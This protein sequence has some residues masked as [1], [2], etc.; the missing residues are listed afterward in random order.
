MTHDSAAASPAPS[1]DTGPADSRIEELLA[2][3]GAPRPAFSD[4]ELLAGF[5]AVTEQTDAVDGPTAARV[6]TDTRQAELGAEA[7]AL[8]M[9]YSGR[10]NWERAAYWLQL[11]ARSG[12]ADASYELQTLRRRRA[13]S[14]LAGPVHAP[15]GG[16]EDPAARLARL[17]RGFTRLHEAK[18][19]A[20]TLKAI[21]EGAVQDLDYGVACFNLV[22]PDGDL[23]VVSVAGDETAEAFL[24]GRVGP[25]ARWDARL[26][27]GERWGDVVFVSHQIGWTADGDGVPSWRGG[28]GADPA[29]NSWHAEDR[30]LAEVRTTTGSLLGVL[31]VDLP[32]SGLLP[33]PW[34]REALALY[35][36]EVGLALTAARLRADAE[37][38]RVRLEREDDPFQVS[39]ARARRALARSSWPMALAE[40]P[41]GLPSRLLDVNNAL[42]Q[43]LDRA[44]NALR[45]FSLE[46]L[47]HPDDLATWLRVSLTRD[48]CRVRLVRRD[49][50]YVTTAVSAVPVATDSGTALPGGLGTPGPTAP[51]CLITLDRHRAGPSNGHPTLACDPLTG[52][53][54]GSALRSE[55]R[56]LCATADADGP[57][58]SLALLSVG[59]DDFAQLNVAHGPEAGDTV[60]VEVVQRL[61]RLVG[62]RDVVARVGGDEFVL[63]TVGRTYQQIEELEPRVLAALTHPVRIGEATVQ[64][65]ASV[66]RGWARHGMTAEQL[67]DTADQDMQFAKTLRK[68]ARLS[69]CG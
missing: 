5:R 59:L 16:W 38:A 57:A 18:S 65:S 35:A 62:P 64:L 4:D 6:D 60:L 34:E 55:L 27:M 20:H 50:S 44:P 32:R 53:V 3:L 49:G 56:R 21:S 10:Q 33:G 54:T 37:R 66:G 28:A 48:T 12:V 25:R 47:I 42:C 8:G 23:V 51:R 46:D 67:L 7:Y 31:S 61:K 68:T 11:A 22:R 1:G 17:R 39:E 9:E 36:R 52:A 69:Y 13:S 40:V 24:T 26:S 30:L 2:V 43:L 41:H 58:A 45:E 14:N 29:P 15:D 63:L 19:L